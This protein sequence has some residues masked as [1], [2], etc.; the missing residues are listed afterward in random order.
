MTHWYNRER[1]R[2]NG[3]FDRPEDLR[4]DKI[5]REY[6]FYEKQKNILDNPPSLDNNG[7]NKEERDGKENE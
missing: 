3:D 4:A 5:R 6:L 2:Y 7:D 1:A